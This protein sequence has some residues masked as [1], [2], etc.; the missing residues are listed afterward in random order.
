MYQ[1]IDLCVKVES[2]DVSESFSSHIGVRQGDNLSTNLFKLFINDLPDVFDNSCQLVTLDVSKLSCL[3]YADDVILLYETSE[4]LQNCLDKLHKY[5][6]VWGLQVN[7]K[8]TKSM[9]F[10]N[11][12]R[13]DLIRFTNNKNIVDNVRK[14]SYLGV[15]FS[16]SGSFTEAK[17]EL[18][19]KGLKAYFKFLKCFE[20]HR[21][22]M[23]MGFC[24]AQ[25]IFFGQH[26]S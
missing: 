7:I 12:G 6:E 2:Q 13:L 10:N 3:M 21:P 22:T 18:Y 20:H 23:T 8:K 19:Q 11:T 16:N 25:N 17:K 1:N 15:V 5:C 9:I 26:K 14:Y 24:F 4:G